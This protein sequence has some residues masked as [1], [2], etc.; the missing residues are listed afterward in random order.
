MECVFSLHFVGKSPQGLVESWIFAIFVIYYPS[1][2]QCKQLILVVC[3]IFNGAYDLLP[4]YI[5]RS[6]RS[7]YYSSNVLK[8]TQL[9]CVLNTLPRQCL[10]LVIKET[11]STQCRNDIHDKIGIT[12]KSVWLCINYS[13]PKKKELS[14]NIGLPS[15]SFWVSPLS[16][17]VF[18]ISLC[19]SLSLAIRVISSR[20]R[21]TRTSCTASRQ[22]CW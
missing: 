11:I 14:V 19:S 1:S 8:Q 6:Y 20:L 22:N 3:T 7:Q 4:Y 16:A 9:V 17:K 10:W 15:L 12:C 5:I 18:S 21:E 13:E 2:G